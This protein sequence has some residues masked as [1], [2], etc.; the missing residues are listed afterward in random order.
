VSWP[1][2]EGLHLY[3][4]WLTRTGRTGTLSLGRLLRRDSASIP[5]KDFAGVRP[6]QSSDDIEQLPGRPVRVEKPVSGHTAPEGRA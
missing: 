3:S 5:S 4:R 2:A 6:A 1:L